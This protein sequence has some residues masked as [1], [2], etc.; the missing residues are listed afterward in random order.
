VN[1][2]TGSRRLSRPVR[3]TLGST[4]GGDV[5][6]A[7]WPYSN[8]VAQELPGLIEALHESLGEIV[9]ICINWPV[10][11]GPLDLETLVGEKRRVVSA[12]STLLRLM[13]VEGRRDC[14]K[15]LV[16]PHMTSAELG[17]LVMRGAAAMPVGGLERDSRMFATAELVVRTAQ[18]Q[19][20]EWSARMREVKSPTPL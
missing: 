7:W 9:D 4:L 17:G 5:D 8:S 12:E 16:V 14:A 15:L 19:S 11:K 18:M 13:Y 1:G 6:G 20:A 2:L 10:T 3:L